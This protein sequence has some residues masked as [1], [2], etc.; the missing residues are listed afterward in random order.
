MLSALPANLTKIKSVQDNSRL[1][2]MPIGNYVVGSV[3]EM[4]TTTIA[5][6]RFFVMFA[7][8]LRSRFFHID[9][10]PIIYNPVYE[11]IK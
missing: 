6:V 4:E 3:N 5:K 10:M 8:F 11:S 2:L 1:W 7:A 9:C